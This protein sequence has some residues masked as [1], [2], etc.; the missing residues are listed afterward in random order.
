MLAAACRLTVP[1]TRAVAM[2][3]LVCL[4]VGLGRASPAG[5]ASP[6]AVEQAYSARAGTDLRQFGYDIFDAAPPAA[7]GSRAPV[8]AVPGD[9]VL[10]PGDELS[11]TLRGQVSETHRYRVDSEGRLIIDKIRPLH[12]AGRTLDEFRAE[13]AAVIADTLTDVQSFVSLTEIRQIGVLVLGTV[14]RPGRQEL[15]SQAT[16]LD[17][18][19]AAGGV[20]RGGSLRR[21]RLLR[22]GTERAIDLYDLVLTGGGGAT[23]RLHDGDRIVVPPLGP[24]VAVAGPVKRPGIFELPAGTGRVS[25]QALRDLAGGLIRPAAQRAMRL[26]LKADGG[27]LAEEVGDATAPLLGDGDILMLAPMRE[28]RQG[29]V[30]L[31]GHVLRP[32]P[33]SMRDNRTLID[34]VG[35]RDLRP[36]HYRPFAVLAST[37]RASGSRTLAAV[38]LAAILDGRADRRLADGDSLIVLGASDVDFLTSEPVLDLLR[39]HRDLPGDACRGLVVLARTLA[40]DPDGG[41]ARGPQAQAAAGLVGSRQPCPPVFDEH[42]DLLVFALR[43]SVLVRSGATRPGFFPAAGGTGTPDAVRSVMRSAGRAAEPPG[44]AQPPATGATERGGVLD[45]EEPA[46]ELA[47]HVRHPGVRP[48]GSGTTLR[49]V[50]DGGRALLDGTYPLMGV[51][52]RVDR[53][54]LSRSL[55]AFSPQDV[56]QGR[57]DRTLADG[58]RVHLFPGARVRALVTAL[59]G[60]MTPEPAAAEPPIDPMILALLNEHAVPVRGAVRRPG[61]YPVAD[62]T[63]VGALIAEAGGVAASGDPGSVEVTFG[64]G[65]ARRDLV[66]LTG[67]DGRRTL[68]GVGDAV[69]VNPVFARMEAGAVTITGEVRR[70]GSYDVLRG[71]TLS[72]LIARAGGLTE[73]AY[74][75]GAVFTRESE[76]RRKKAEFESHARAIDAA[77]VRLRQKGEPIRDEQESHARQLAAELRG[78]DPPGR[79]VVEADPA[80]LRTRPELDVLLE[81]EDRIA[82]PKRPL[83]VVVSGELMAPAALQFVSGKSADDYIR[84][85]GGTTRDA[86]DGRSFLLLPDGRAEPLSL[87]SWNHTVSVVPPGSTI[88]VPRDPRPYGFLDMAKDIGG[89]VGQLAL[90]AA[91]I[92]VISR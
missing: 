56:V 35:E 70:P 50:L 83:T 10:G 23:E 71:E 52:E 90:T 92:A 7:S 69:R 85:A 18:V 4:V 27:E 59:P 84:E 42:P 47:G 89:I 14:E 78:I 2:A 15:T 44:G 86:D 60:T 13:L 24:T 63:P 25:V 65:P 45:S 58:D 82:I 30:R 72:S 12:A 36:D 79:I 51:I 73:N 46:F 39:G 64:S 5:A 53:R 40:A 32:G 62:R 41:F 75:A 11:V 61:A 33:R 67:A 77:M 38:D 21:I 16:V 68:V 66:D 1:T 57:A 9:Y 81:A 26:G 8:G 29:I 34:L 28:D 43:Q 88:V 20:T 6:S 3:L 49:A 74:P 37:D 48:L 19:T 54:S 76:R 80:V 31:E 55:L 87:S 22:A 91:S 17:A